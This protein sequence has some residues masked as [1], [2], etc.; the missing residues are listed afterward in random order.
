[1]EKN[2]QVEVPVELLVE[3]CSPEKT[4]MA[5]EEGSRRLVMPC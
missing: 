3:A 4:V 2:D 5:A 1:M